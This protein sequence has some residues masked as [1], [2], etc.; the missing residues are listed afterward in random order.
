MRD[1]LIAF[2]KARGLRQKEVADAVGV[3]QPTYWQYEH[4]IV[5]PGVDIAKKLGAFLG[6]DWTVFYSDAGR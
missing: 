1:W 5:T 2:R 6:F 3:S 4:G